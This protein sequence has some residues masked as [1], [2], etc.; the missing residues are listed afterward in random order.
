M[1][2][3]LLS[4]AGVGLLIGIILGALITRPIKVHADSNIRVDEVK[5]TGSDISGGSVSPFAH[6]TVI[7]FSCTTG[8]NGPRCFVATQ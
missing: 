6:S 3:R 2:K 4:A 1:N 7:G 5:F 8:E